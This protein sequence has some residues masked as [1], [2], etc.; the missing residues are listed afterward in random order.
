MVREVV[1][2]I[3]CFS[4]PKQGFRAS[5]AESTT[6]MQSLLG[7]GSQPANLGWGIDCQGQTSPM[8]QGFVSH[9]SGK[10]VGFAATLLILQTTHCDRDT[11]HWFENVGGPKMSAA[12]SPLP[13]NGNL[14]F[15]AQSGGNGPRSLAIAFPNVSSRQAPSPSKH[16]VPAST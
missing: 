3:E 16:L 12:R 2:T 13:P 5:F 8:E 14:A 11:F 6:P 9:R 7:R 15:N 4:S 10:V 1:Q